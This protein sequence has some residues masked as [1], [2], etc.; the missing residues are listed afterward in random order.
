MHFQLFRNGIVSLIILAYDQ[1]PG[2]IHVN[3]VHNARAN[4]A[5]DARKRIAAVVQQCVHKCT[6]IIARC[7]VHYHTLRLVHHK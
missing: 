2:G 7:R 5:V 6:V 1:D 3:A 4:H